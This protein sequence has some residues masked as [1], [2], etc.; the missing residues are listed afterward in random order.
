VYKRGEYVDGHSGS[1]SAATSCTAIIIIG[2][3]ADWKQIFVQIEDP[4]VSHFALL[5]LISFGHS[6]S[7]LT[8]IA[9]LLL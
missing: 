1:T 8:F 3:F 2:R 7:P 5:S 6:R 4:A 9:H